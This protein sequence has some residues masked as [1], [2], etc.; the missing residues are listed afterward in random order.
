MF[1]K[2]R[3]IAQDVSRGKALVQPSRY[4]WDNCILYQVPG[5][6]IQLC[7]QPNFPGAMLAVISMIHVEQTDI[8]HK[9]N[10]TE[11]MI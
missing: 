9:K 8:I 5:F 2:L 3:K 10:L 7:F 1:P 4:P 11:P 6:D